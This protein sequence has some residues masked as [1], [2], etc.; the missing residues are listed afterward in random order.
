MKNKKRLFTTFAV[1]LA[2]STVFSGCSSKVE[3]KKEAVN[4]KEEKTVALDAID[5]E[6][7]K[8]SSMEKLVV[9]CYGGTTH[10]LSILGVSDKIVAQ[11][12]MKKFPQLMK[13]YPKFEQVV[14]PGSFDNINIE[15]ILK[16]EPDMAF[17]GVT[18]KKGNKQIEDAGIPTFTMYIGSADID[19]L[20]KEFRNVGE[21]LGK[22][23]FSDKLLKYWD[24]KLN[25]LSEIV[26]KIPEN[27][28]KKVYYCGENITSASSGIWGNSFITVS[29]G[30]NVLK[31]IT[32]G[33]KGVEISVEQIAEFNPDVVITQKRASGISG[34][35]GDKRVQ[36]LDFIK[37]RQV[38]QCPTGAFWWDRPSPESPLGFMWLA[39]TLYPEETASI[40][41]KKETIEFYK[42][43]Y[44]YD[45]TDEEYESFF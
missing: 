8:P 5:R 42:T 23:E 22:K 21:V 24:E 13:M 39:K 14:N 43:F 15:E 1:A 34:I 9:T 25:M 40:N 11:P 33:A 35:I 2:V 31:D 6:V 10:E 20:K 19:T 17:V 29:G 7:V 16:Q 30:I 38:Y 37:N 41:L 26:A 27:R 12:D 18:S 4:N 45:L 32:K 36:D 3:E 28:R 44:N